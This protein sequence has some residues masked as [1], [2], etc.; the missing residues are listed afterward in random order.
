MQLIDVFTGLD[1]GDPK[2]RRSYFEFDWTVGRNGRRFL[3]NPS[4]SVFAHASVFS[5]GSPCS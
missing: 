4:S 3:I 5:I 1:D 2:Q